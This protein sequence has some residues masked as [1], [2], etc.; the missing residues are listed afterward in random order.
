MA[1][2]ITASQTTTFYGFT[3]AG[4]TYILAPTAK[5]TVA[6]Q[7]GASLAAIQNVTFRVEGV[8]EQAGDNYAA[9]WSNG[10]DTKV[11]ITQTGVIKGYWG[12]YSQGNVTDIVN[13]GHI[14]G[15]YTAIEVQSPAGGK[16]ANSGSIVSTEGAAV[17]VFGPRPSFTLD[18]DGLILGGTAISISADKID[19][20]FGKSS[21]IHGTDYFTIVNASN[22]DATAT[23]DNAGLIRASGYYAYFGGNGVDQL[24]NSGRIL[25]I[26]DLRAGA[27]RF[28]MNGGRVDGAVDG[29]I[30]DDTFIIKKG[31][32]DIVEQSGQGDDT[33]KTAIS[34]TLHEASE[35]ETI[36]L[37]G[38]KNIDFT[39]S[40]TENIIKGNAGKNRI[41]GN[42]GD[43]TLTGGGGRDIFVFAHYSGADTITDFK[44]GEDRIE[45]SGFDWITKFQHLS[46]EQD[47]KDVVM[48]L[49]LGDTLTIEN[50]KVKDFDKGD[51]LFS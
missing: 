35:I 10:T 29:G 16:I 24:T 9:L 34:Y 15:S 40:D 36:I 21:V 37:T 1:V 27:D 14:E 51:F 45:I 38:K 41:D 50:A 30:G 13:A 7:Y 8:I 28:V 5:F 33:L 23:L 19:M 42:G 17:S 31:R 43:D 18:N 20:S 11:V 4:E 46:F 22:E 47:G 48:Q 3:T 32:V 39:G 44:Q 26:I 12:V 6:N 49:S 2:R 25:G